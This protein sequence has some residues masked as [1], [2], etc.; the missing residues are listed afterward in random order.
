MKICLP[1]SLDCW[2]NPIATLQRAC[3]V[4]NP[5]LEFFSYS[6]PASD[7]DRRLAVDFWALPNITVSS[8][9]KLATTR[10]DL[11]HTASISVHNQAAVLAA[12]LRSGGKA[13]Y[14]ATINLQVGANDGKDW[15]L[16]KSAEKLATGIVSVSEAAGSGVRQRCS[17]RFLGI[18]PNGFDATY[19]DPHIDDDDALPESVRH[20]A[21]GSYAIYVGA[22]EP[23]KNP[24]FVV[25]LA[26]RHPDVTFIGVGYVHPLGRHFEPLVRS[27]PNYHWLGHVDRRSVR[28]LIKNAGVMVFPSEREGLA[29]SAIET[30][31]MG[32]P[33]I[34]Q[35]KSSMPELI[36]HGTNGML[37]DISQ[38]D[39]W[40]NALLGYLGRSA[41]EYSRQ[42]EHIR[43]ETVAKYDWPIIGKRYGEIYRALTSA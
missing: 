23:R 20:F 9:A 12:K 3:V 13:A 25:E 14:L 39:D 19:F 38:V 42:K 32:V 24:D 36:L 33:V 7:E 30:L 16:L 6:N 11:I 41:A 27:L 8:Q 29:L 17:D 26:R 31:G 34:A 28:A 10:F 22:L 35:P 21:P 18:I 5:D 40:S 15:H 1:I 43:A 2:R 4:M 37:Y